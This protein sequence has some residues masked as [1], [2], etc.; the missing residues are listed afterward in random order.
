MHRLEFIAIA[1]NAYGGR[2]P[3]LLAFFL[4]TLKSSLPHRSDG[5]LT[6]RFAAASDS[7]YLGSR[8]FPP[9]PNPAVSF[10]SA[11]SLA[12]MSSS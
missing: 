5:R 10:N 12:C 1:L 6:Q 9:L 7:C 2:E 4:T 8:S 3:Y 11:A